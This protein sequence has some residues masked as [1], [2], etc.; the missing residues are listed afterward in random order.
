MNKTV[1]FISDQPCYHERACL[2]FFYSNILKTAAPLGA[3][4]FALRLLNGGSPLVQLEFHVVVKHL[5]IY[6]VENDTDAQPDDSQRQSVSGQACPD[7]GDDEESNAR[8][9]QVFPY[10]PCL[11]LEPEVIDYCEVQYDEC[12]QAA[13]VDDD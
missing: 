2:S 4:V 6:K 13:E 8:Q 1:F 11:L 3:A 10:L 7:V 5:D 9:N 12:R